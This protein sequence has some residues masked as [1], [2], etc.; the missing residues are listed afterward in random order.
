MW[1]FE[2]VVGDEHVGDVNGG[3]IKCCC[4]NLIIRN[5][6]N[7][8]I[9]YTCITWFGSVYAFHKQLRGLLSVNWPKPDYINNF[10]YS[11]ISSMFLFLITI[12]SCD[13]LNLLLA[14][15]TLVTSQYQP[16][17]SSITKIFYRL[18]SQSYWN[19]QIKLN[20]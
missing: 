6:W 7:Y 4:K 8:W 20:Y 14:M 18:I 9:G 11:L 2:F 12:N 1:L 10:K 3:I 19:I 16:R 5:I 13:Y 17:L 15:N